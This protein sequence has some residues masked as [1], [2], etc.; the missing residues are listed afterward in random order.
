[1]GVNIRVAVSTQKAQL[2]IRPLHVF[3]LSCET[4]HHSEQQKL[5]HHIEMPL[6]SGVVS[7]R[8]TGRICSAAA[9]VAVPL[10]GASSKLALRCTIL[11]RL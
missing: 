6:L 11:S 8:R 10:A 1:M 3:P 5:A 9:A 4:Y 7:A 2:H